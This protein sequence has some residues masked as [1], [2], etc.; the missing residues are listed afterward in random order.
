ML[1]Q[2]Y[3]GLQE[4]QQLRRRRQ[5]I[6]D[7]EAARRNHFKVTLDL[8]GRRVSEA[9]SS[10]QQRASISGIFT[11]DILSILF[12]NNAKALALQEQRPG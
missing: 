5:E 2:S 12:I 4:R 8:L 10:A 1:S 9:A 11:C 7:A 6:E 3:L